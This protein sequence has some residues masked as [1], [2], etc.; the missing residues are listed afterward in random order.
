M[1]SGSFFFRF[2]FGSPHPHRHC[3]HSEQLETRTTKSKETSHAS[4]S[5]I[6]SD[7]Q[8]IY[9]KLPPTSFWCFCKRHEEFP[10]HPYVSHQTW[11]CQKECNPILTQFAPQH[12]VKRGDNE[13]AEFHPLFIRYGLCTILRVWGCPE[14]LETANGLPL[15]RCFFA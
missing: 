1:F 2:F 10:K 11:Q 14:A 15:N 13:M 8:W 3:L 12:G 9:Q 5:T 4:E 7:S 6:Y